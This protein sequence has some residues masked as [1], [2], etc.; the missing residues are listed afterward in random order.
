MQSRKQ[1]SIPLLTRELGV[2]IVVHDPRSIP[3]AAENGIDIRP[4]DMVSVSVD[5]AEINRLGPPWGECVQ[6]GEV[7]PNQYSAVP[8]TQSV[9]WF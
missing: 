3:M 9:S 2:R 4:G 5:Y 8:Y 1:D 7:L 6:D